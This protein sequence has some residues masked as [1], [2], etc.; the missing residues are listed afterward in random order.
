MSVV[1][2]DLGAPRGRLDLLL[3]AFDATTAEAAGPLRLFPGSS[4]GGA[5]PSSNPGSTAAAAAAAAPSQPEPQP[6]PPG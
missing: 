3:Q 1:L 2:V 5:A 4:T 6:E